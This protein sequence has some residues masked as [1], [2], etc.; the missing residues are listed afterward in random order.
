[1]TTAINTLKMSKFIGGLHSCNMEPSK[2]VRHCIVKLTLNTF[3]YDN[4]CV[5]SENNI[6][7]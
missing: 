3:W 2:C 6:V 1:M 4:L 7:G 5:N